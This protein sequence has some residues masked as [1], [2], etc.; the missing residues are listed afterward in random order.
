MP[1]TCRTATCAHAPTGVPQQAWQ[2]A[3]QL[4]HRPLEDDSSRCS[5]RM[6]A[7]QGAM[8][9]LACHSGQARKR[10][11]S[12]CRSGGVQGG[13]SNGEP[14]VVRIAFKPTSTIARQQST[15]SRYVRQQP[16]PAWHSINR[17]SGVTGLTLQQA[18]QQAWGCQQSLSLCMHLQIT[19]L[20]STCSVLCAAANW[21]AASPVRVVR[22]SCLTW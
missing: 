16:C 20:C 15:V 8:R 12:V 2:C 1:S 9:C 17:D 11:W 19:A 13:L 18:W 6:A 14:I 5:R 21:P 7:L 4:A 22:V 3:C 10:T